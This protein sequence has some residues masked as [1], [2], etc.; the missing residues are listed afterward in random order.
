MSPDTVVIGCNVT[1]T[2]KAPVSS[3]AN[4]DEITEVM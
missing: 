3:T 1:P 4:T 2:I